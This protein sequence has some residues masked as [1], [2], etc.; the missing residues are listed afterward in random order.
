MEFSWDDVVES[1]GDWGRRYCR[2]NLTEIVLAAA[3]TAATPG[4]IGDRREKGCGASEVAGDAELQAAAEGYERSGSYF[5]AGEIWESLGNKMRAMSAYARVAGNEAEYVRARVYGWSCRMAVATAA[6]RQEVAGLLRWM[7][8]KEPELEWPQLREYVQRV[9]AA[10]P[11]LGDEQEGVEIM[12]KGMLL[13]RA[14]RDDETA[15]YRE[16]GIFARKYFGDSGLLRRLEGGDSDGDDGDKERYGLPQE[17]WEQCR[18]QHAGKWLLDMSSEYW[19]RLSVA[20]QQ[21]YARCYQQG[22]ARH[23]GL[24]VERTFRVNGVEIEMR[25]IPPGRWWMGS[26]ENEVG[27]FEGEK[28]HR[29]VIS[30]GYWLQKT[31]ITQGQWRQAT[32]EQPWLGE[33][34]AEDNE[35]HP[36]TYISWEDIGEKLLA[37]WGEEWGIPSEA[38]WEYACRSGTLSRYYWGE[39]ESEQEIGN[40]AWYIGNHQED[41]PQPVGDKAANAWGLHDMVGNVYEWCA[42]IYGDYLVE[43]VVDPI[44]DTSGSFRVDRGGT[45]DFDSLRYLRSAYRFGEGA[46]GRYYNLGGRLVR[47]AIPD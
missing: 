22:Y 14:E 25:L 42:D 8:V 5:R 46:G 27:R 19:A 34:G 1:V 3:E 35:R 38:Q 24:P 4:Q 6:G 12:V 31:A 26:P 47:E 29:V 43:D 15:I 10:W 40:Y 39:D 18:Y 17:V 13:R 23:I 41:H 7:Q 2:Q 21:E 44:G 11:A 16:L 20:E 28:Q 30:Q 9:L 45:W 33:F 36:A 32:G 37:R